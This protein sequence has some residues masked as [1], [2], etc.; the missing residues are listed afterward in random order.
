MTPSPSRQS[1]T[2]VR[3]QE[4]IEAALSC[5][6]ELGYDRATMEDI[7]KRSGAS[8]GSIY[9]HFQGKEQL[10]AAVYL[11]GIADYQ[12]G[13][14]N[15]LEQHPQARQG[16]R[17]IVRYHLQWVQD[18]PNWARYLFQ[19]RRADVIGSAAQACADQNE[20]FHRQV[21]EWFAPHIRGGRLRKLPR[22]VY[23]AV[24][25]G[26][27]MDFSRQWLAGRT[28]TNLDEA[29]TAIGETTWQSLRAERGD[30]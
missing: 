30:G 15:A 2:A 12:Q 11:D 7:R 17:A 14:S 26:P 23:V 21:A 9:H 5:F 1:R 28:K 24:L 29:A 25:L 6:T 18:H 4:I 3:R 16:L 10:A 13:F 22:D 20:D 27:S 8:T 19:M